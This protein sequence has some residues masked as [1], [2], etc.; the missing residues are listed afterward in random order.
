MSGTW[1]LDAGRSRVDE[2]GGLAGMPSMR[3]IE[4]LHI[5]QAAND[6]L[7]VENQ[8]NAGHLRYYVVGDSTTTPAGQSGTIMMTTRREGA[9]IV[10]EGVQSSDSGATT[11]RT[12]VRETFRLDESGGLN[13]ETIMTEGGETRASQLVYTRIDTVGGCTT[14]PSPCKRATQ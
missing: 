8:I 4:T 12:T 3:A 7:T 1:R 11:A 14:W 13:I 10:A 9:T 2:A 5:S 6:S